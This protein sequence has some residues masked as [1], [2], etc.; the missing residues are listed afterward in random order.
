M[1]IAV[2]NN[3]QKTKDTTAVTAATIRLVCFPKSLLKILSKTFSSVVSFPY[4]SLEYSSDSRTR[5]ISENNAKTP[6][7]NGIFLIGLS[8][9]A[10]AFFTTV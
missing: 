8:G 7:T 10:S 3:K 6:L 5:T 1:G 4:I 9:F 2:I